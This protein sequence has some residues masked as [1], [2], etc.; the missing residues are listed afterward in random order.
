MKW[1]LYRFNIERMLKKSGKKVNDNI[2]MLFNEM[3]DFLQHLGIFFDDFKEYEEFENAVFIETDRFAYVP[4]G[5]ESP[6]KTFDLFTDSDAIYADFLHYYPNRV[7]SISDLQNM[8]YWEFNMLISNMEGAV[9]ARASLRARKPLKGKDVG[10]EN[11]KLLSAQRKI[12][13]AQNHLKKRGEY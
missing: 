6:I 8:P 2:V 9:S 11:L 5:N 13:V 3:L 10:S 1:Q 12:R 4:I 7:S